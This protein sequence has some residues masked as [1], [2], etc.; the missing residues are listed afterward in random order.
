VEVSDQPDLEDLL[1]SWV[2]LVFQDQ[3]DQLDIQER[4]ETQ[5]QWDLLDHK[6][7]VE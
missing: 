4:Q 1:E 2:R 5:E 7:N 3:M 6:E